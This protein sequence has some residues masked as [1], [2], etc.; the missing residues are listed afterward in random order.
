MTMYWLGV[1]QRAHVLRGVDLG[2]AQL[3]HGRKPP[4]LRLGPGD[5]FVYYSPRTDYPDG[6]PLKEFTAIGVIADGEPWQA[7]DGDFHPWWRRVEWD[8]SASAAPIAPL[9][10]ELDLSRDNRNWGYQL[11]RGLLELSGHDFEVIADAMGASTLER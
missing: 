8:A 2:I 4:L 6:A 9:L 5:G 7:D 1:V 3:N 11:R 10:G